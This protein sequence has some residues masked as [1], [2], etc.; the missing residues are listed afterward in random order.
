MQV[1]PVRIHY[2]S[3]QYLIAIAT[4]LDKRENEVQIDHMHQSAF[5]R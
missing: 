5:I 1:V 2:F 3:Q 4:F